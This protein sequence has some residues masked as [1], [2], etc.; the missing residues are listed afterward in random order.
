MWYLLC[1]HSKIRKCIQTFFSSSYKVLIRLCF[2]FSLDVWS[3]G[4]VLAELLLG[5]PIFPG[6]SGVDQLVEIIKVR[7]LNQ[8]IW[9][10]RNFG[11]TLIIIYH[12]HTH[13][14]N[15]KNGGSNPRSHSKFS[16]KVGIRTPPSLLVFV[17][18]T[19]CLYDSRKAVMY[20]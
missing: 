2:L 9:T 13:M 10:G 15:L 18:V 4:C 16:Y 8:N 6:D 17:W 3:A 20:I 5:Q 11:T 19:L 12:T 14:R 7:R 1:D